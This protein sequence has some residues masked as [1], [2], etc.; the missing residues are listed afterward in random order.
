MSNGKTMGQLMEKM[1]VKANTRIDHREQILR[2]LSPEQQEKFLAFQAALAAATPDFQTELGYE[3]SAPGQANLSMSTTQLAER[4][5][6]VSMTIEMPFKY[7]R[8]LPDPVQGW[9]PDRSKLLAR[10]CLETLDRML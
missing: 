7:N 3:S 6:A 4:H 10:A 2:E 1:R 5:G 8:D 9:S